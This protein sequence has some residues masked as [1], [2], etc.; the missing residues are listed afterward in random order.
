MTSNA[1]TISNS[2]IG[3]SFPWTARLAGLGL[4]AVSHLSP[5]AAACGAENLFLTPI[6]V[7][8]PAREREW[9]STARAEDCTIAGR[10]IAVWVW[11]G[12]TYR[13]PTVVLAHG[14]GG[15][16]SQLG[17]FVAPLRAE[18]VR[19]VAFDAPA[20]GES[21]GRQTNL[22]QFAETVRGMLDRFSEWAPP[23]GV[24]AH[25][26]GAAATTIALS[27]GARAERAVFL[28][29]AED[30][31]HFTRLF[32]R[33]LGL[34]AGIVDRMQR[35]IERRIGVEWSAVRGGE[36]APRLSQPMLVI[37]DRQ[38]RE[39]PI[40]HGET[41]AARWPGAR[42]HL[43]DGL[44]HHRVLRDADVVERAVRHLVD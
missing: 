14:W 35:R 42:L 41:I 23:L 3:R 22:I 34:H 18:G 21:A 40:S 8:R 32:S 37:H 27:R 36:L 15:R 20:H 13:A 5:T 43:T 26:F 24:V 19:V 44:G 7:A 16:G 39:V 6:R 28:A 38:D 12:A 1:L 33:A 11:E 29:P 31:S 2:T 4:R 25:S 17:A 10:R 30:Y 9:L